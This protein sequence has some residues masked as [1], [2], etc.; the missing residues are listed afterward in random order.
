MVEQD[1]SR[2]PEVL[3]KLDPTPKIFIS[4]LGTTMAQAGSFK[5]QRAIDHDLN[6]ALVRS[7]KES[8]ATIYVLISTAA[9]SPTSLYPYLKMKG[10]LEEA[11]KALEI[12]YTILVQPGVLLGDRNE[13]RPAEAILSSIAK[14]LGAISKRWLT[15]W[16]AQDVVIIGKAVV[17][18]VLQCDQGI[19]Q[20]GIWVIGQKDIIKL[21]ETNKRPE[22]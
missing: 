21:G 9:S 10:E 17:A 12:P 15:D 6:L 22:Q 14:G 7:A 13:S 11:V 16:W 5:A 3:T 2:W 1:S 4:A 19:R 8:G 18:A 20:P